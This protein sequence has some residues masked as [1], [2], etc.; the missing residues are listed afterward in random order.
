LPPPRQ[1]DPYQLAV[2][3]IGVRAH[4]EAELRQKLLR[5]GCDPDDVDSAV[6][7]LR[8]QGYLDDRAFAQGLV[9]YRSATRGSALIAAEL[10]ARGI[11]RDLAK[12]ALGELDRQRQLEV[13]ARFVERSA[14]LDPRRLAA[15]LQR[16]GFTVEVIREVVPGL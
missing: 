2:R 16:R 3:L 15:R 12:A 8:E 14:G 9:A 1:T 7:R 13:A 11:D 6:G 4:G 10:A 5:R